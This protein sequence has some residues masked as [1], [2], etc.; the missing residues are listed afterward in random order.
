VDEIRKLLTKIGASEEL[1]KGITEAIDSHIKA[2]RVLL[3]EEFETKKKELTKVC[4]EEVKTYKRELARKT[5]IFF[6]SRAD[7]IESQ[8]AK[9]V[10]I[11]EAAA[12]GKLKQVKSL[13]E[14][15]QLN[16]E[17]NA[18][19]GELRRQVETLSQENATLKEEKTVAVQKAAKATL[20]AQKALESNRKYSAL[21]ESKQNAVVAPVAPATPVTP[22]A[23]PVVAESVQKPT[24]PTVVAKKG[25]QPT[26]A[27]P[28]LEST[29]AKPTPTTGEAET[30]PV[31]KGW[32]PTSIA[33]MME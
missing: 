10:A 14:G 22:P 9:Q 28:I 32:D 20:I 27:T 3:T 8:I 15:I 21:L 26:T 13:L 16:T 2:Q 6:E 5:Q 12:E 33:N 25:A 4:L 11:K 23:K 29:V 1:A 18:E 7:K 30:A 19:P 31:A 24:K 17:S